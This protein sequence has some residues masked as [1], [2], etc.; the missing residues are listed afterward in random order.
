MSGAAPLRRMLL[1]HVTSERRAASVVTQRAQRANV[2]AAKLL[3]LPLPLPLLL[4]RAPARKVMRACSS[5]RRSNAS[6]PQAQRARAVHLFARAMRPSR[7]PSPP[8]RAAALRSTMSLPPSSSS[9][10]RFLSRSSSSSRASRRVFGRLSHARGAQSRAPSSPK[11]SQLLFEPNTSDVSDSASNDAAPPRAQNDLVFIDDVPH[12]KLGNVGAE[13]EPLIPDSCTP[14]ISAAAHKRAAAPTT[15]STTLH[16]VHDLQRQN[17]LLTQHNKA[18]QR[19]N[20][21]LEAELHAMECKSS[22]MHSELSTL[23]GQFNDVRAKLWRRIRQLEAELSSSSS[24]GARAFGRVQSADNVCEAAARRR[25]ARALSL[26]PSSAA[27]H[28]S[29]RAVHADTDVA[30][31]ASRA[32]QSMIR[33]AF[34]AH[35]H[36]QKYGSARRAWWHF[37]RARAQQVTLSSFSASVRQ[38]AVAA[39]ASDRELQLLMQEIC[40]VAVAQHTVMSWRMFYR[41]YNNTKNECT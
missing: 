3:P 2:R 17:E 9:R 29:R 7:S 31:P 39:D 32:R 27:S 1:S 16:G 28:S 13:E 40:E 35:I 36:A 37:L 11:P 21:A 14:Y 6:A 19:K 33:R 8:S 18:L 38:L 24:N 25:S 20:A 41:F 30:S 23:T 22:A 5:A 15:T 12:I 10:R 34:V 26:A 4:S